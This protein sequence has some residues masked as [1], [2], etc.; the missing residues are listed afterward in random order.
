MQDHELMAAKMLMRCFS[1]HLQLRLSAALYQQKAVLKH[2]VMLTR[3]LTVC[4]VH[5]RQ[6]TN[7]NLSDEPDGDSPVK[8][9]RK[10]RPVIESDSEDEGNR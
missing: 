5:R 7:G 10:R 3:C 2:H 6:P 1:G 9:V 8:Q 4:D